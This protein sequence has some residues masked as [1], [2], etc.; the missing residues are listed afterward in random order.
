M[1][2]WILFSLSWARKPTVV[3]EEATPVEET[4]PDQRG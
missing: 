4:S 2:E 1:D 3:E